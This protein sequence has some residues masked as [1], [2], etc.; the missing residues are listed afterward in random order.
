MKKQVLKINNMEVTKYKKGWLIELHEP[1]NFKSSIAL[2]DGQVNNML[3]AI[4]FIQLNPKNYW[5]NE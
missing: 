2:T 4:G 3:T 1:L 5:K